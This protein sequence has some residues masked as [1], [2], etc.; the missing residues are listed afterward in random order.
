MTSL[1]GSDMGCAKRKNV[2]GRWRM[3]KWLGR[4]WVASLDNICSDMCVKR[5]LRSACVSS[6]SDQ[7]LRCSPEEALAPSLYPKSA[8]TIYWKTVIRKYILSLWFIDMC[9]YVH[10]YVLI[11]AVRLILLFLPHRFLFP[12]SVPHTVTVINLKPEKPSKKQLGKN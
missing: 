7:R 3:N 2:F 12:L 8:H 11:Y 9:L 6:H 4:V 1:K 5:R 10:R